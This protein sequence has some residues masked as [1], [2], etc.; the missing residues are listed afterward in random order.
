MTRSLIFLAPLAF[1]AGACSSTKSAHN[2]PP[3]P[4][5]AAAPKTLPA[6]PAGTLLTAWGEL[7]TYRAEA[8]GIEMPFNLNY[9]YPLKFPEELRV[10]DTTVVD[11]LV[12][13]DGSIRDVKLI[14]SSGFD[15]VDRFVINRFAGAQS[16]LEIAATDPA[17]YVVRQTFRLSFD[18]RS[19]SDPFSHNQIGPRDT[20]PMGTGQVIAGD[21]P[22]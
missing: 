5:Q 2:T 4:A 14:T 22:Y 6:Q 11:V 10:G 18:L 20:R 8:K 19:G 15:T 21:R 1:L 13:R 9:G 12:D 17:P 7:P 3:P 16:L